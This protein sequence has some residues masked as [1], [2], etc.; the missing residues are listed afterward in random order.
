MIKAHI[1]NKYT[2]NQS[3]SKLR[4]LSALS[5]ILGSGNAKSD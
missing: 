5:A 2:I 1:F 3:F 4:A